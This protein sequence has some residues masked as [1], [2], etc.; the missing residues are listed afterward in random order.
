MQRWQ[1]DA[2]LPGFEALEL[3]FPADYDGP[4]VS[5][6]VRLPTANAPRRAVRARGQAALLGAGALAEHPV[7]RLEPAG[8]AQGPG[9][10][11]RR[12]RALLPVPQRPKGV[13]PRLHAHAA[14]RVGFR[15]SPQ[16]RLRLSALL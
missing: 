6:L 7:L 4:V 14:H 16:A 10:P 11:C 2:L 9:A 3:E 5:T 13:S 12:G 8:M 15:G 1:P